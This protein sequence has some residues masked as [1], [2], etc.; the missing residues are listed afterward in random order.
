MSIANNL[1][2]AQ[3]VLPVPLLPI[4]ITFPEDPITVCSSS[5]NLILK[6]GIFYNNSTNFP[7]EEK[8]AYLLNIS[9]FTSE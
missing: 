6:F 3:V 2:T 1:K 5:V 7:A 9:L 4:T 8:S